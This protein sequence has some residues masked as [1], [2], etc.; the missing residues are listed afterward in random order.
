KEDQSAVVLLM[1]V[2]LLVR[3]QRRA[4]LWTA[5]AALAWGAV[6]TRVVVPHFSPT[7]SF[8]RA[9]IF[10]SYGRTIPDA[11][12]AMATHPARVVEDLFQHRNID[13][14]VALLG[15]FAFVPLL[16]PSA[17][18]PALPIVLGDLLAVAPWP[19]TI[20]S[21]YHAAILPFLMYAL[22]VGL[23]RVERAGRRLAVPIVAAAV[24]GFL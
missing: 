22:V 13:F 6:A 7:G 12:V 8:T 11:L 10:G 20:T 1:A 17:L 18:I 24:V 23:A 14:L 19:H 15:P 3:R 4:A 5:A 9:G 21:Q 16:A 2:W